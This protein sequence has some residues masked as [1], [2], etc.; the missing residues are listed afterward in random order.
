MLLK[1][2]GATQ[3]EHVPTLIFAIPNGAFNFSDGT[4]GCL[5][6]QGLQ[7]TRSRNTSASRHKFQSS[8]GIVW[9]RL[10]AKEVMSLQ[11]LFLEFT[12][13]LLLYPEGAS[14]TGMPRLWHVLFRTWRA[15]ES[16]EWKTPLSRVH[17]G[18]RRMP[19]V[20]DATSV[21]GPSGK[22]GLGV[23]IQH[24]IESSNEV[25][26]DWRFWLPSAKALKE[27]YT[28]SRWGALP[29]ELTDQCLSEGRSSDYQVQKNW[30]TATILGVVSWGGGLPL[31]LGMPHFLG[32]S[33]AKTLVTWRVWT[34]EIM[35]LGLKFCL[36]RFPLAVTQ[37]WQGP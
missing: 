11:E 33:T 21:E 34:V 4:P 15:E 25:T 27:S 24:G 10:I 12:V 32:F 30:K 28:V 2:R 5:R 19:A 1:E 26:F 17:G 9:G 37:S 13:E 23:I 3:P 7:S 8:Y 14:A 22:L 35:P 29:G 18:R 31:S 6:D 20:R 16:V 36:L